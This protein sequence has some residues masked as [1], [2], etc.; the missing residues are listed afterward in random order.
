MY[1]TPNQPVFES[2]SHAIYMYHGAKQGIQK[3]ENKMSR[4]N[5]MKQV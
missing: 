3:L 1:L 5:K 2:S 4:Q